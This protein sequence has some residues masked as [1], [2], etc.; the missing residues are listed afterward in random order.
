MPTDAVSVVPDIQQT[1][2]YALERNGLVDQ[3]DIA[4]GKVVAKFKATSK[5]DIGQSIALSPDG[6]TLY[7]LKNTGVVSNIADVD[8]ATEAVRKVLPA[9]SQLCRGARL[10]RRRS[11]L[12]TGG[13]S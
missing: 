7:V 10:L 13:D 2:L 1:T 3:I 8:T 5:D 9:P 12:R 6:N 11:A 4:G